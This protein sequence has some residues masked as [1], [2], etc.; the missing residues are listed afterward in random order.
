MKCCKWKCA[1]TL[2]LLILVIAAIAWSVYRVRL[3]RQQADFLASVTNSA[4]SIVMDYEAGGRP[5]PRMPL[6]L[7]G[8]WSDGPYAH[9]VNVK[10]SNLDQ[11]H[12]MGEFAQ[13]R[14]LD[15]SSV[16]EA[17]GRN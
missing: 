8:L 2:T 9:V 1:F 14:E 7:R 6:W 10:V 5:A 15:C 17:S 3:A 12:V 16:R 4:G 11:L 13:L